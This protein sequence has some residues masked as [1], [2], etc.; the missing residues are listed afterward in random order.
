MQVN[1]K[2][3]NEKIYRH[4]IF[5]GTNFG[6]LPYFFLGIQLHSKRRL[7]QNASSFGKYSSHS[8]SNIP[9]YVVLEIIQTTTG[10]QP[11]SDFQNNSPTSPYHWASL[12]C[13]LLELLFKS[14][15]YWP[16]E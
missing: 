10:S 5:S 12:S 3:L 7:R 11:N 6:S 14:G 8:L 13:I 1:L 15:K 2:G 4:E 16:Y 9:F